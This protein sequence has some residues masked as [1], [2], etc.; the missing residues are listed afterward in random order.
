VPD[1]WVRLLYALLKAQTA[2]PVRQS[3]NPVLS[4]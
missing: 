2:S 4:F 3:V 1:V